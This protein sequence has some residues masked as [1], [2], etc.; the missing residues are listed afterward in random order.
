MS[1]ISTPVRHAATF[2]S[3]SSP[4]YCKGASAGWTM[5]YLHDNRCRARQSSGQIQRVE[6]RCDWISVQSDP[7]LGCGPQSSMD[8]SLGSMRSSEAPRSGTDGSSLAP[9]A[10]PPWRRLWHQWSCHQQA[11]DSSRGTLSRGIYTCCEYCDLARTRRKIQLRCGRPFVSSA[12]TRWLLV[13]FV[14]SEESLIDPASE[15]FRNED[16]VC[17]PLLYSPEAQPDRHG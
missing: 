2:V 13:S 7:S 11:R 17:D 4:L 12:K 1:Q 6:V 3:V 10:R 5:I 15:F 14:R 8:H 9:G 16:E